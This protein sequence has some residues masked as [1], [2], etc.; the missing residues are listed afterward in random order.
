MKE[1]SI[2]KWMLTMQLKEKLQNRAC[3]MLCS[4]TDDDLNDNLDYLKHYTGQ[5]KDYEL[6][7]L[8]CCREH[9]QNVT[10]EQFERI[11]KLAT[12]GQITG[13]PETA[14]AEVTFERQ[15]QV[16]HS[17]GLLA[18]TGTSKGWL[19]ITPRKEFVWLGQEPGAALIHCKVDFHKP[20]QF[21]VLGDFALLV[22]DF[23]NK[24]YVYSVS[25]GEVVLRFQRGGYHLRHCSFPAALISNRNRLCLVHATDWNMLQVTDLK[26]LEVLTE[27]AD[28]QRLDYFHCRLVPSP[29]QSRLA[30][31]G[32]M[33]HPL[34]TVR[35]WD[36][37]PW[38]SENPYESDDGESVKEFCHREYVWDTPLVWLNDQRLAVWGGGVDDKSL[39][40]AI[41]IFDVSSG[42]EVDWFPGPEVDNQGWLAF[43]EVLYAVSPLGGTTIWD[44]KTG[45]MLC[46]LEDF[47]PTAFH[48]GR[49]L[50][51]TA[52]GAVETIIQPRV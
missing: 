51:V 27:R 39:F 21:Q 50:T 11:E 41:R 4:A 28:Y 37:D 25:S 24:G 42:R 32:W 34:G 17:E 18:V 35:T 26:T 9:L 45:A 12:L 44:I 36:I 8:D 15:E 23:H 33:W 14:K 52:D 46:R 29:E 10:P 3:A 7:C 48:Q 13:R 6:H 19:G 49:F 43:H 31:N 2:D 1:L 47:Q 38:L 5:G 22:N 30:E 20:F 16:L 40:P